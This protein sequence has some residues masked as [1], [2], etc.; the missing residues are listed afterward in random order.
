[1][2]ESLPYRVDFARML[3]AAAVLDPG[4]PST[5]AA[6]LEMTEG[7]CVDKAVECAGVPAAQRLCIDATR[8]KGEVTFVGECDDPLTIRVS[9]DMIRKG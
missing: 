2:V 1:V 5:L 7:R 9:P 6:I 8:C 4:D 3:G